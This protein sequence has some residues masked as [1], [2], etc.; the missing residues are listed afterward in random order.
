MGWSLEK[1]PCKY[2]EPHLQQS[3][4]FYSC[5]QSTPQVKDEASDPS[6]SMVHEFVR[7]SVTMENGRVGIEETRELYR[8]D[9]QHVELP[10][11]GDGPERGHLQREINPSIG[12]VGM[13][14]G[15]DLGQSFLVHPQPHPSPGVTNA[16]SSSF[17]TTGHQSLSGG[18]SQKPDVLWYEG[19]S[20]QVAGG[21]LQGELPR[22]ES[23]QGGSPRGGSP[24]RVSLSINAS[25][26]IRASLMPPRSSF[27]GRSCSVSAPLHERNVVGM[28]SCE[29][30][31]GG[32]A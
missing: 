4:M 29:Q 20:Y 24:Q 30:S 13:S 26:S 19:A 11:T 3:A 6:P 25:S 2:L 32:V 7:R 10:K 21:S 14:L 27:V 23:P 17:T 5:R 28:R 16:T 9:G 31:G 22:G 8:P 1:T 12:L 18:S 15:M